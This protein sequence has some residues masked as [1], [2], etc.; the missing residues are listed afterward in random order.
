MD[1]LDQENDPSRGQ[2]G[3]LKLQT[4]PLG[5]D[6]ASGS[7]DMTNSMFSKVLLMYSGS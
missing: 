4:S 7:I 6:S 2:Y 3:V 1:P 5:A